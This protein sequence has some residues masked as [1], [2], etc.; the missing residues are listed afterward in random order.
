MNVGKV[1]YL[2]D[3]LSPLSRDYLTR[4]RSDAKRFNVAWE[5]YWLKGKENL[6][7]ALM[8][9]QSKKYNVCASRAYFAVFLASVAALIKLTS[10]R[11]KDNDWQHGA[12]QAELNRQLCEEGSC[13]LNWDE[14][15]WT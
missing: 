15:Q 3:F 8:A 9:N 6:D 2:R 11:A 1:K 5:E 13:H 10:F 14:P 4:F 12:V 7:M